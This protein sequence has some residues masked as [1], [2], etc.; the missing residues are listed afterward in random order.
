MKKVAKTIAQGIVN[1]QAV[2]DYDAQD[3]ER[4]AVKV[5]QD[6][7]EETTYYFFADGS[8]VSMK[9]NDDIFIYYPLWSWPNKPKAPTKLK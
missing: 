2:I 8:A 1:T 9:G 6:P 3:L 4:K 7:E 5:E